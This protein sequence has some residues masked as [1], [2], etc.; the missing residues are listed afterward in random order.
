MR[1]CLSARVLLALVFLLLPL[2][3]FAQTSLSEIIPR[4]KKELVSIRSTERPVRQGQN[5]D[6]HYY[7]FREPVSAGQG[8]FPIGTGFVLPDGKHVVTSARSLENLNEVEIVSDGSKIVKAT[9]VG[10]DRTLDLAVLAMAGGKQKFLG[11]DLGDSKQMRVGESLYLFG[12]SVK[13]V[14]LKT[15]LNSTDVVE[16]AYGRHWLIDQPTTPAVAGG[17]LVDSRG[18]VVGMAVYNAKGPE[19][20]G[21]VLPADLIK[22]SVKQLIKSGKPQRAWLGIVPRAKPNLDDLDHIRGGDVKGGILA[23]NLIVDG[24]AAKGGMQI[25]DIILSI[26]GKAMTGVQELFTYLDQKKAGHSALIKIFRGGK[27]TLEIKVR[28]GELPNARELPN[29]ENIL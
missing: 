26:D 27:G 13:F 9:V 7:F 29:V 25:S 10:I 6:P 8:S 3:S 5:Y 15:D 20:F 2:K 12:R 17:P 24:P 19:H 11:L 4:I 1:K 16:G 14:L 18:R 28:L 22:S 21:T 23:E